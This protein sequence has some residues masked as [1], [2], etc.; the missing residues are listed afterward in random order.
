M[1]DKT[2]KSTPETS[3]A[4]DGFIVERAEFSDAEKALDDLF[5]Q[6]LDEASP[7]LPVAMETAILDEANA[8]QAAILARRSTVVDLVAAQEDTPRAITDGG[9]GV[10]VGLRDLLAN[11]GGWPA[12]GGLVTASA[13]GLWIGLAPPAFLPDPIEL[14][15]I[16]LSGEDLPDDSYD[17]A[18]AVS[19]EME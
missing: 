17:L 14:A 5:A 12:L 13:V 4:G 16:D 3:G 1:V 6:A 2:G 8:M 15:G 10:V 9:G 18:M 11:L 7:V 19:E